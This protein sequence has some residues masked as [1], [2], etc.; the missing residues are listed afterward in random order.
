MN[1]QVVVMMHVTNCY[2]DSYNYCISEGATLLMLETLCI[3]L[4]I[5]ALCCTHLGSISCLRSS[6]FF[7]WLSSSFF[8]RNIKLN[9]FIA[10]LGFHCRHNQLHVHTIPS[11][12]QHLCYRNYVHWYSQYQRISASDSLSQRGILPLYFFTHTSYT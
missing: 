9:K 8:S 12:I 2:C 4:Y 7:T 5:T 10:V 3:L 1:L 11:L 6:Y